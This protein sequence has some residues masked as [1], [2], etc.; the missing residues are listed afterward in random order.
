MSH[1]A[2]LFS[3]VFMI[4]FVSMFD[5]GH[6]RRRIC[7]LIASVTLMSSEELE[8]IRKIQSACLEA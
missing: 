8:H 5:V 3:I 2:A 7:R 4:G 6:K 1:Y